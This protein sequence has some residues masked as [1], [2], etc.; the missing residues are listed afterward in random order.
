M[1]KKKK[2]KTKTKGT[3]QRQIKIVV[4][5]GLHAVDKK[6]LQG[7]ADLLTA[8][9]AAPDTGKITIVDANDLGQPTQDDLTTN[10]MRAETTCP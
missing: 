1:A 7:I 6:V 4:P 8:A 10:E 5:G 3:P 9:G 2:A